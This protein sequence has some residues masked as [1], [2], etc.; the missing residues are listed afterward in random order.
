MNLSISGHHVD[1]TPALRDYM[2]GKLDRIKRHF[3]HVIDVRAVMAVDRIGHKVEANMHVSGKDIHAECVDSDMY[4]AIDSI[5]DK[6]DRQ[7]IKYKS[8]RNAHHHLAP[9][10]QSPPEEAAQS[11]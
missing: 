5:V 9:K 11:G 7:V 10:H 8:R 2:T 4:A 1:V 6:L 3:D